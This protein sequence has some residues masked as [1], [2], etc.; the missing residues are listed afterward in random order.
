MTPS[1]VIDICE[2]VADRRKPTVYRQRT[3][4]SR[5]DIAL[6]RALWAMLIVS[7]G[8]TAYSLWGLIHG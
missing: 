6:G 5:R 7:S 2:R 4:A 3:R 1:R 8:V